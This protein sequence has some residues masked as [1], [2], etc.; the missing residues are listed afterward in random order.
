MSDTARH[1]LPSLPISL[2]R[3]IAPWKRAANGSTELPDQDVQVAGWRPDR[4]KVA[5]YRAL[6]GSDA[7][8]PLAFPQVAVMALTMDLISRWSYPVRALGMVHLG[9]VVEAIDELPLDADWDIVTSS[10]A[11]R[12][13]RSG[14][15]FDVTGEISVAGSLRWRSRAVYLSRSRSAAGA[16]D[17]T[18]PEVPQEGPWT[19]RVLM[20]A[21]EGIG[22]S[23]GRL[24]GDVNPIH[25]HKLTAKVLGFRRAIA[26]GWW[27][28]G[29]VLAL[30]GADEA[31]AGRRLEIVYRRP[32]E[33]PSTPR[34]CWRVEE[35]GTSFVVLREKDSE[36]PADPEAKPP[37]PLV[38]G[39]VTG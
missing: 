6:M 11:G 17:S 25:L 34:L 10:S 4:A 26:H 31:V 22:R 12:H 8:V 30:L 36:A 27:S 33:L 7:E 2:A 1:D 37:T 15:E 28:T 16:Q 5:E 38:A 24:S 21:P 20:D 23:F 19:D 35:S 13:V 29:R 14:M 32:I 18:V 9:S 3:S 39:R